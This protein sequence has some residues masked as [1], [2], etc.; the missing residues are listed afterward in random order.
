MLVPAFT[1]YYVNFVFVH[2]FKTNC[3]DI[4]GF[5]CAFPCLV[6]CLIFVSFS[7]LLV[8]LYADLSLLLQCIY[9]LLV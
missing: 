4:A 9:H 7:L 2:D 1:I 8:S 3:N 6:L 5:A